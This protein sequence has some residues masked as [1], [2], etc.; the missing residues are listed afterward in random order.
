MYTVLAKN[1]DVRHF[2]VWAITEVI[3]EVAKK[4]NVLANKAENVPFSYV[5]D[6]ATLH[7]LHSHNTLK[8]APQTLCSG[9]W[10]APDS[11]CCWS[12]A[13]QLGDEFPGLFVCFIHHAVC[14]CRVTSAKE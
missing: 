2:L 5:Y 8:Q 10:R 11:C 6:D 3:V 1:F 13:L 7:F 12:P 4:L 9:R 14:A